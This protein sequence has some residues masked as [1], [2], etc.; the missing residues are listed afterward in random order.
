MAVDQDAAKEQIG[1][2][3]QA[4]P[5]GAESPPHSARLL[6]DFFGDWNLNLF[7]TLKMQ[8]L[9]SH[10]ET[11]ENRLINTRMLPQKVCGK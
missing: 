2:R 10:M 4:G 8:L 11:S 5:L 3:L 7:K 6:Q 9:R 1:S